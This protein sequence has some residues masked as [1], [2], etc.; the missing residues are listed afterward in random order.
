MKVVY[1]S[2]Q[3]SDAKTLEIPAREICSEK[4]WDL[5]LYCANAED[6]DEDPLTYSE[7][8]RR[9]KVAD[10]VL[11]RCMSDPTRMKRFEKY[12]RDILSE[13]PGYVMLHAGNMEVKLLSFLDSRR[14]ARL[15]Q[16]TSRRQ[17]NRYCKYYRFT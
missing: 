2:I 11:I 4:G 3:S 17:S 6:I 9:T 8:V 14:T 7:L 10:L 15:F 13:C 1:I 5:D 12:E 16:K